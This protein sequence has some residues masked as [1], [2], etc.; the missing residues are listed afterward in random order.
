M[1]ERGGMKNEC[2]WGAGEGV[3]GEGTGLVKVI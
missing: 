2:V 1:Y 3:S